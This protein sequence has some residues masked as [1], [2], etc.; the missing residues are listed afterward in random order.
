MSKESRIILLSFA[1]LVWTP[2]GMATPLGGSSLV[3]RP[4]VDTSSGQ[5]YIYAGGFFQP[6]TQVGVFS[7][8]TGDFVG[9]REVTPIL[10]ELTSPGVYTVRG[11]GTGD[12][13]SASALTQSFAFG[14]QYGTATAA[15][16]NYTFG[17]INAFVN[18]IGVQTSSSAGVVAFNTP[19]VG[20]TGVAGAGT[21]N[22]WVFTPTL[23]NISIP[24]GTT[25]GLPG[26]VASWTLNNPA[27]SV[28]DVN[29]T[30]SAVVDAPEPG[31][32]TLACVG[33]MLIGAAFVTRRYRSKA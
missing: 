2:A 21:T 3:S 1:C 15:T 30:Y 29:R 33:A 14:L 4:Y 24:L 31:S 6:G 5:V 26:Q 32:F 19:V 18:T 20:G 23:S 27:L 28:W 11:V 8:F 9:Q 16:G 10:F 22:D 13:V 25:F 17:F 12:L 7:L